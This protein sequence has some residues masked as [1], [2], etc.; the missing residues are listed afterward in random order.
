MTSIPTRKGRAPTGRRQRRTRKPVFLVSGA[1]FAAA[2][3]S[4]LSIASFSDVDVAGAAVARAESLAD[5]MSRR[6]PGERTEAQLTKIKHKQAALLAERE[7][8]E[9]PIPSLYRPAIAAFVPPAAELAVIPTTDT[10]L[11]Q[12]APLL[13][14]VFAPMTGSP[15]FFSGGGGGVGGGGG[16]GGGTPGQTT[17]QQPPSAPGDTPAVPEPGT[18]TM[19]IAG[20]GLCG[21]ALRR[22]RRAE[23]PSIGR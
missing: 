12:S 15:I 4:V 6:S 17:P 20:F 10:L 8:P 13:P 9:V 22:R 19:M 14:A 16:G 5:L 2:L 1:A 18:W 21:F 23:R 11:A 7:R 3:A